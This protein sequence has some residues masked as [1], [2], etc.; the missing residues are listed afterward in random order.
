MHML[1]SLT[2]SM[3]GPP[4][5]LPPLEGGSDVDLANR[6]PEKM[7]SLPKNA[8]ALR[9]RRGAVNRKQFTTEEIQGHKFHKK[10][11]RRPVYCSLCREFLW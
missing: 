1:L 5:S 8:T 11:F 10:Y 9:G 3:T 7:E 2:L 6:T 4:P